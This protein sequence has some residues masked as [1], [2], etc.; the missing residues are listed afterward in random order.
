MG[1]PYTG[2]I[3]RLRRVM[4]VDIDQLLKL[5]QNNKNLLNLDRDKVGGNYVSSR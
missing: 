4:K 2:S 1:Q 3:F 5:R